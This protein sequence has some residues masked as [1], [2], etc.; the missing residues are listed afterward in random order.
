M[1]N[2]A[3]LDADHRFTQPA[4]D[5]CNDLRF[6]IVR[7]R[8]DNGARPPRRIARFENP[9]PDEHTIHTQLHQ[10]RRIRRRGNPASRKVDNR[11]APRFRH[12]A[13]Q[14]IG[15]LNVFGV[16]KEFISSIDC[17]RRISL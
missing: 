2:F 4:A 1:W 6:I 7:C 5:F 15:R 3:D 8:S 12:L 9:R 17:R 11:Q 14:F 10:E 13:H 16:G